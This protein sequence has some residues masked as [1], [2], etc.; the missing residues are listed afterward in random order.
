MLKVE[1]FTLAFYDRKKEGEKIVQQVSFSLQKGEIMGLV[2]ESGSG[3]S[4]TALAVLGL[5][6]AHAQILSGKIE[7]DGRNLLNLPPREF[8]GLRGSRI[9]MIFQEPLTSLNPTMCV[10][11]QVAEVLFLHTDMSREERKRKVLAV[12][13]QVGLK[14]PL[15]VYT[16]YPHQLSGGMRQRIMIAMAVILEPDLLIADEP[17]TALDVTT[18]R[19]IL[20]LLAQISREK[21]MSILLI[22]HDLKLAK[23][24]CHRAA[25]M[26]KG[27]IVEQGAADAIFETPSK[28]YTKKLVSAVLSRNCRRRE[29][30]RNKAF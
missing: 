27:K 12:F 25:V 18:E 8:Q 9:S 7:F 15:R 17:T 6:P 20:D 19:Q 23:R 29:I 1:D 13:E 5:L 11:K 4:M 22:T 30:R 24:Y 10:G 16:A 28:E 3:K 21:K 2:G 26:E 14:N